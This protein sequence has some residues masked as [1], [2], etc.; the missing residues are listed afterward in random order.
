MPLSFF[1]AP[2]IRLSNFFQLLPLPSAQS[3]GIPARNPLN[4]QAANPMRFNFSK[5]MHFLEQQTP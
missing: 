1:S 2:L 4:R 3:S 5:R